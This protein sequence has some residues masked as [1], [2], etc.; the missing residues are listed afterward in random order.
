MVEQ[1]R[2][3]PDLRPLKQDVVGDVSTVLVVLMARLGWCFCD[4]RN[5]PRVC[6]RLLPGIEYLVRIDRGSQ[7]RPPRQDAKRTRCDPG[8]EATPGSKCTGCNASGARAGTIGSDWTDG[9]QLHHLAGGDARV[10]AARAGIER[11][12]RDK[13]CVPSC[14]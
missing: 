13:R 7:V 14:Q 11:F 3:K 9:S 12:G 1:L 6:T 2:F 5:Q 8:R 10:H 4:R